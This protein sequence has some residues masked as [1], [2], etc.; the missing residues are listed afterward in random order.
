MFDDYKKEVLDCYLKMK[1]EG[2]LSLNLSLPTPAR[3]R[4]EC[5]KIYFERNAEADVAT[6]KL[7]FGV[8]A[9]NNN[10]AEV[11]R[12]ID[13][14]RFRPLINLI[15]DPEKKSDIKNVELLAWLINF[16]ARPFGSW[17][18]NKPSNCTDGKTTN[19]T[20]YKSK[21]KS[22]LIAFA[23]LVFAIGIIYIGDTLNPKQCMYWNGTNYIPISCDD[24]AINAD[25]IALNRF[26]VAHQ[27]RI[28]SPDSI[29]ENDINTKYYIKLSRDSIEYYSIG[30]VYPAD[31]K[32]PLKKLSRYMYDKYIL[33]LKSN[34]KIIQ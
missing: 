26:L 9:L 25:K 32:K 3:I 21:L 7:F 28:L 33:P 15:N 11:I 34:K 29:T 4:E 24:E 12:G 10:Y 13:I 8:G 17:K 20:G 14:D 6:F 22:A 2:T 27:K 23:L 5:L 31:R 18:P 16:N 19:S 1:N 30:G